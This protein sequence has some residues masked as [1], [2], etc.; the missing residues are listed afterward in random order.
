MSVIAM[1]HHLRRLPNRVAAPITSGW[2]TIQEL[3]VL[4][5]IEM[6]QCCHFY[7]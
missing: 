7:G 6:P 3:S 2:P 1:F 5:R 4:A